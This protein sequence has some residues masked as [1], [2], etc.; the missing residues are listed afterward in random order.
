MLCFSGGQCLFVNLGIREGQ[1]ALQFLEFRAPFFENSIVFKAAF[2]QHGS[3][4]V[5]GTSDMTRIVCVGA[6][7][8]DFAAK[9][10]VAFQNIRAGMDVLHSA[11]DAP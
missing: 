10:P 11:V 5:K 3:G 6:D 7:G 1:A 8:D 2:F 4:S 9:F